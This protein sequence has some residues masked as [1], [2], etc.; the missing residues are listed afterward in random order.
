MVTT[1][2]KAIGS[3]VGSLAAFLA[4]KYFNTE[5]SVETQAGIIAATSSFITYMIPNKV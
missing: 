1:W 3:F 4:L 2:D 5:L